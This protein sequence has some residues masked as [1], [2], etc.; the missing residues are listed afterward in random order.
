[1][2]NF[3]DTMIYACSVDFNISM[4]PC[5]QHLSIKWIKLNIQV[6]QGGGGGWSVSTF[7]V[8]LSFFSFLLWSVQILQ[9]VRVNIYTN[10]FLSMLR[11]FLPSLVDFE[12]LHWYCIH[13]QV[14]ITCIEAILHFE[15]SSVS[16][17]FKRCKL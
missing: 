8:W 12:G 11:V 4:F 14:C 7:A 17:N 2:L 3:F 15:I 1:M 6:L 5:I 16:C 9:I 10:C 13:L